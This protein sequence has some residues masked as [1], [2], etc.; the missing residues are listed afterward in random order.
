MKTIPMLDY[1]KSPIGNFLDC[2][3]CLVAFFT[4]ENDSGASIYSKTIREF[5]ER[6]SPENLY[7]TVQAVCNAFEES[8]R[9]KDDPAIGICS[10]EQARNYIA[11]WSESAEPYYRA[12]ALL[13]EPFVD[14]LPENPPDNDE[15]GESKTFNT[16]LAIE[17]QKS[18]WF[19]TD[20]DVSMPVAEWEQQLT[21]AGIDP[22]TVTLVDSACVCP[23]EMLSLSLFTRD[24][25]NPRSWEKDKPVTGYYLHESQSGLIVNIGNDIYCRERVYVNNL[26]KGK[27]SKEA[28]QILDAFYKFVLQ[29]RHLRS[30]E[31]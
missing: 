4:G 16:D 13:L 28:D 15:A 17:Q 5:L 19:L 7:P 14:R 20:V 9:D 23:G 8:S 2:V 31:A 22:A 1:S 11:L 3:I 29:E 26:M 21:D 10:Q 30:L 6:D 18:K 24:E 25:P 12:A 27:Q